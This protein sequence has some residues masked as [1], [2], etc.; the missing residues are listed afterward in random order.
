MFCSDSTL[1]QVKLPIRSGGIGL[2]SAF[3]HADRAFI[4]SLIASKSLCEKIIKSRFHFGDNLKG[5]EAEC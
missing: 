5:P 4:G 1:E 3:Q 2:R